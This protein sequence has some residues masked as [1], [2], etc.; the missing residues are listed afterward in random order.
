MSSCCT[1]GLGLGAGL[2]WWPYRGLCAGPVLRPRLGLGLRPPWLVLL[3]DRAALLVVAAAGGRGLGLPPLLRGGPAGWSA[4]R[5]L[6]GRSLRRG[7]ASC[8]ARL[9]GVGRLEGAACTACTFDHARQLSSCGSAGGR[10]FALAA[11]LAR[12][13]GSQALLVDGNFAAFLL[14]ADF[15]NTSGVCSPRRASPAQRS[16]AHLV[17]SKP[18]P[19]AICTVLRLYGV[20]EGRIVD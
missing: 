3:A 10:E 15:G 17:V 20:E 1:R 5:S 8:A 11:L 9:L 14:C 6:G 19:E 2:R 18:P 4:A 13:A 12:A 7:A 16:T